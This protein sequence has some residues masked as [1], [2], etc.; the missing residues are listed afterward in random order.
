[1]KIVVV[2]AGRT[3]RRVVEHLSKNHDV[4]VVDKDPETIEEL[5]DLDVLTVEGDG[6]IPDTLEEAEVAEA[7]YLIA[8]TNDDTVNI[9]VCSLAKMIGDP[10]TIARVKR[11]EYL[12]LWGRGRKALGV[13]LMVSSIPLVAK[14]IA[15]VIGFS[16]LRVLR[17][18]YGPLFVGDAVDVPEGV[19]SVEVAGRR[20]VVGTLEELE[21]AYSPTKH[22]RVLILGASEMGVLLGEML[23]HKGCDVKIVERDKAKAEKA[24]SVLEDATL[25]VGNPLSTTLWKEEE[26]DEA[27]VA[28]AAF[29]SDEETLMGGMLSI[30]RGIERTFAI[31]H[32]GGLIRLFE[33]A[34]L[35]AVSPEVVTADR[36][37]LAT[38][39]RKVLGLVAAIPGVRVLAIEVDES[40]EGREPSELP[41]I[42]G[43]VLRKGEVILPT[44][45]FHLQKG[46]IVTLILEEERAGELV[47]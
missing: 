36:I 14:S 8:T 26:L 6:S 2:G 47:L 16:G 33:G 44:A 11:M 23:L 34:G 15:N 18:L 30:D 17:D 39:G 28:V 37:V 5:Q 45:V 38:R 41:G 43:P 1:M 27:D 10:F 35:I 32:D 13:N 21:R 20:V 24:A 7:D 25:V 42:L 12:R 19:W 9:I 29:D 3:G 31:V 40:L 46:D 22:S 4:I